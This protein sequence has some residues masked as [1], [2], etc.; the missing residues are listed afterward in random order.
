MV[1]L[2]ASC[3]T[4]VTGDGSKVTVLDSEL[5]TEYRLASG[6]YVACNDV[7]REGFFKL[8]NYDWNKE[9]QVS[10]PFTVE[11]N[12]GSVNVELVGS[13]SKQNN[14]FD[15]EVSGAELKR[16]SQGLN[17]NQ[18]RVL[19]E[20]D[21]DKGHILPTSIKVSPIKIAITPRTIK[22][23][24]VSDLKGSFFVN[25]KLRNDSGTAESNPFRVAGVS[26][27]IKVYG[28]CVI[29]KDTKASL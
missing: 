25:V 27:Q 23:V 1:S 21:V 6:E 17:T 20:A 5:K 18:F 3:N 13:S 28:K 7:D 16:M 19:F 11:G 2:L 24:T 4:A 15:L 9:T 12:V 26:Q 10:V 22:E 8:F 29:T 14:G